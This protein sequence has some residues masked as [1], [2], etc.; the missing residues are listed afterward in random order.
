MKSLACT[1][2]ICSISNQKDDP[3]KQIHDFLN[4]FWGLIKGNPSYMYIDQSDLVFSKYFDRIIPAVRIDMGKGYDKDDILGNY[5]FF[6]PIYR[7]TFSKTS[8]EKRIKQ[9][10]MT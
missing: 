6:V 1:I 10:I 4:L 8:L 9:Y 5:S 3:N 2:G 7:D